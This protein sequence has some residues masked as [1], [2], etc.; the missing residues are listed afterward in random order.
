[1]HRYNICTEICMRVNS[2][3]FLHQ[4][5]ESVISLQEATGRQVTL[6]K[7]WMWCHYTYSGLAGC[8]RV[9]DYAFGVLLFC[10][11]LVEWWLWDENTKL[12]ILNYWAACIFYTIPVQYLCS[13]CL[14]F[15][16]LCSILCFYYFVY[17]EMP[18]FL[19]R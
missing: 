17:D 13:R 9:R 18:L 10:Y 2:T 16:S 8:Y 15:L 1:M 4:Y 3:F 6:L 5:P 11:S 12:M 19:C 7:S 14:M